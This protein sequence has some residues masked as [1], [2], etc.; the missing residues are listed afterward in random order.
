MNRFSRSFI[1]GML[2]AA[3]F[4]VVGGVLAQDDEVVIVIGWEQEPAKLRP[5]NS[6]VYGGLIENF[7]V[8]NVW[9][10][11]VN[12][13]IYPIMVEEIPS[14]ENGLVTINEDGDTV[15]RYVLREG[16]LWSDGEPV[17][18]AD[19]AFGH[20]IYTDQTTSAN[21]GRAEYS[22]SV[23]DLV[24]VDDLNFDM[25]YN[26]PF[27]DYA[28][29]E[30]ENARCMYPEHVLGPIL[31]AEGTLD[32]TDYFDGVGVVGYGPYR[33]VEWTKGQRIVFERNEFWDGQEPA[34]DRVIL[35]MIPESAQMLNAMATGEIDYVFGWPGTLVDQYEEIEGV[36]TWTTPAVLAD[37]IWVNTAAPGHPA[38]HDVR[39]REAIAYAL[40]RP[41][42][43]EGILGPGITVP[44][45][46]YPPNLWIEGH[47]YR[48]YDVER[49]NALLDEAGW[50]DSNSNGTR[51]KD[52]VE[53]VLRFYTTTRS[54][55]MDYQ[56]LVQEYLNAVGIGTQVI[57]TSATILFG[58]FSERGLFAG[59]DFDLAI[60]AN[61]SKALSPN[62]DPSTFHCTAIGSAEVPD[63]FNG[64]SWCDPAYDEAD[65]AIKVTIDPAERAAL[66]AE[67][68]T[69][70]YEGAFWHGLHVR[71]T[72]FALNTSRWD[73]DSF[74]NV[75]TLTFN[76][77][78]NVEFWQPAS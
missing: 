68:Q 17:T 50:V 64:M 27:P 4:V 39:V 13:E 78:A 38:L 2:L 34:I 43:A 9:D 58:S 6:L 59:H 49:A 5:L 67:A 65:L 23:K 20:L 52:G 24:V 57:P 77:A 55:R 31:E 21:I 72:Y 75:G 54:D 10:W 37:A 73:F 19:C 66:L 30:F 40:D 28:A 61:S 11:D 35:R 7:H 63:G 1:L 69:R 74:Q 26:G 53:I 18:S 45:S 56:L 48:E 12:R 32:Q 16:M 22:T 33:L 76:W 14:F 29:S 3:L 47:P 46:W 51:D 25:I 70:F 36:Q 60:F 8:R 71:T 41:A 62:G 42:M 44:L 15:V